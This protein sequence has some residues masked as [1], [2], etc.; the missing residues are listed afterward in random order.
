MR[1]PRLFPS[2]AGG[3]DT[4]ADGTAGSDGYSEK[5]SGKA[6][7]G[8]GIGGEGGPYFVAGK[9]LATNELYVVSQYENESLYSTKLTASGVNF[10]NDV[11][12]GRHCTAKFRY[13]QKD[14]PVTV[15]RIDDDTIEV[16]FDAPAR[17][18]T[19]GQAVVLYDGDVCLGGATIDTV[20]NEEKVLEYLG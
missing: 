16:V 2:E 10:I 12:D 11:E 17:A 9:N 20:Y 7:R 8:L 4:G 3:V 14:V 18:V 13:R 1:C 19:P 6:L 15:H 5:E